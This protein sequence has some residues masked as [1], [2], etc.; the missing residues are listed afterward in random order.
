MKWMLLSSV[1][2]LAA[3]AANVPPGELE[4]LRTQLPREQNPPASYNAQGLGVP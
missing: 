2:F 3:C 1:I 4:R